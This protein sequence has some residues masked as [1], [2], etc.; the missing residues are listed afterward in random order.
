MRNTVL[1][2]GICDAIFA[3]VKERRDGL[4]FLKCTCLTHFKNCYDG[5]Y[6]KIW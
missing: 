1:E 5:G 2:T 6:F 3:F 4:L